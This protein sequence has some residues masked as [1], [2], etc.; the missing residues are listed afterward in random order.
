MLAAL[1]F[2]LPQKDV[3]A[4]LLV[5]SFAT[6]NSDWEWEDAKQ[7]ANSTCQEETDTA[8]LKQELCVL[9]CSFLA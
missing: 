1:L 4:L 2:S 6:G 7:L 5:V 8:H 3:L 9:L